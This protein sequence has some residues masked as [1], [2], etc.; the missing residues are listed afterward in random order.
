M[1]H[2]QLYE[3]HQQTFRDQMLPVSLLHLQVFFKTYEM[4]KNKNY[5][6]ILCNIAVNVLNKIVTKKI[7]QSE[8]KKVKLL[9]SQKA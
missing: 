2:S 6:P 1:Q 3:E 8:K 5:R 9:K 7:P 4:W